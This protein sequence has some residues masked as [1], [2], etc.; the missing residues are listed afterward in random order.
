M[1]QHARD[2][3]ARHSEFGQVGTGRAADVVNPPIGNVVI[4]S[5]CFLCSL[6]RP[7]AYQVGHVWRVVISES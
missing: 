3:K 7:Q 2:G 4:L 6:S 5:N 1:V